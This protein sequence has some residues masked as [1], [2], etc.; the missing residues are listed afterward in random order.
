MT[1]NKWNV[2]SKKKREK[3]KEIIQ[4]YSQNISLYLQ[5]RNKTVLNSFSFPSSIV[6]TCSWFNPAAQLH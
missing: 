2:Q 1:S 6:S 3:K 4:L 5:L